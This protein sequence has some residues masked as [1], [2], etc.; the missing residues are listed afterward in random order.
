MDALS[1]LRGE[2][3]RA[4]REALLWADAELAFPDV[5]SKSML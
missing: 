4:E 1:K 3:P 5:Q 2:T